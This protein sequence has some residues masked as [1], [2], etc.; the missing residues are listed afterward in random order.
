MTSTTAQDLLAAGRQLSDIVRTISDVLAASGVATPHVDARWIV[1]GITGID[2]DR[3]PELPLASN[4]VVPLQRALARREAREPL[5]LVLGGTAFLDLEITCAPGVF[6]PRPETEVLALVAADAALQFGPR[7]R[8]VELCSGSGVISCVLAS[9]VPGIELIAADISDDAVALT[10]ENLRHLSEQG[11]LASGVDV[12][13]TR[14]D[15]FDGIDQQGRGLVDVVVANPPYLPSGERDLWPPEV[16]D[17]DPLEALV[18]GVKGHEI[19]ETILLDAREWL[20]PGGCIALEI[21]AR[22]SSE[23]AA[24]ASRAGYGSVRLLS[25]LAGRERVI[26]ALW[27]GTRRIDG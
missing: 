20:R 21:D 23:V 27:S 15:V 19:V 3:S 17:H 11:V 12:T 18:G 1:E 7:P 6:V 2:P 10:Q 9:R 24:F 22:R 26:T 14:A 16:R 13:V 8:V 25:D 4:D 5:Q